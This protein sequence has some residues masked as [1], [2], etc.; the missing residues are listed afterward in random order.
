[1]RWFENLSI[2]SKVMSAFATI[3]VI[4]AILGVFSINRLS[5]VNDTAVLLSNNYL[6]AADALGDL[7]YNSM[8]FRQLQAAHALASTPQGKAKEAAT[9]RSTAEE[10]TKAWEQYAPT[11]DAGQERIL[12]DRVM[13]A[14]NAYVA[15]NDKFLALS[16][17]NQTAAAT[18]LYTGEMRDAFHKFGDALNADQDYQLKSGKKEAEVSAETYSSSRTLILVALGIAATLCVAAGWMIVSGVSTPI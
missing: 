1:M 6:A 10:V 17:A 12:A 11:V 13:P 2:R 14:W 15:L 5:A 16:D 4:T 7:D 18:A 3:L 8:R 9:M